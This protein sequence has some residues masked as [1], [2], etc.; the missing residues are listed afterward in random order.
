MEPEQIQ[1][2][3]QWLAECV[4]GDIDDDDINGMSD[5]RIVSGIARH[6]S[7]G[8]EQFIEDGT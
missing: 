3:R 6:Y 5:A 8:I 7:G 1:Q 2:A 4:W